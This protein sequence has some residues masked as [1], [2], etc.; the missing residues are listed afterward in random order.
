MH[1]EELSIKRPTEEEV[2]RWEKSRVE[3]QLGGQVEILERFLSPDLI[4]V[5]STGYIDDYESYLYKIREGILK[6]QK[7]HCSHYKV[8]FLPGVVLVNYV[9]NATVTVLET[10]MEVS[11]LCIAIWTQEALGWKMRY[12]QS[13]QIKKDS[14]A[15]GS[16]SWWGK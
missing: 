11:S 14:P 15:R 12:L 4:Y 9:M 10:D 6:Y 7:M 2:L 13:T 8:E 1:R 3:A 16:V 5:H